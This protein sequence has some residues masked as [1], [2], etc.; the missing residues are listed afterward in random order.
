M[1]EEWKKKQPANQNSERHHAERQPSSEFDEK[2]STTQCFPPV[3][4]LAF[5]LRLV[6]LIGVPI[7]SRLLI[8][9]CCGGIV[10]TGGLEVNEN[11]SIASWE[12]S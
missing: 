11:V 5:L 4:W 8:F 10:A 3:M 12:V 1:K 2:I 6:V 7:G 9:C